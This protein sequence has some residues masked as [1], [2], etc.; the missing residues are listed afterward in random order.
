LEKAEEL[1]CSY[2]E[3]QRGHCLRELESLQV[4]VSIGRTAEVG[5]ELIRFHWVDERTVTRVITDV[6][7]RQRMVEETVSDHYRRTALLALIGIEID[8]CIQSYPGGSRGVAWTSSSKLFNR[9]FQV[10]GESELVLARLLKPAL[11]LLM[12][13]LATEF[14]GLNFEFSPDGTLLISIHKM[15]L[16]AASI[17][18]NIQQPAE[19]A[20]Q[21]LMRASQPKIERLLSVCDEV[22]RHSINELRRQR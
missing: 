14:S 8:A 6:K 22:S 18:I 19:A 3:Y 15:H 16:L 10:C 7:G 21:L 5:Y 12:E 13:Q 20:K 9:H 17:T 1:A 11:V 2:F 4:G